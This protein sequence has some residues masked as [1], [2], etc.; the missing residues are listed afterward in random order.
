MRLSLSAASR[1]KGVMLGGSAREYT[2]GHV[3]LSELFGRLFCSLSG[4]DVASH[5]A[6]FLEHL[7]GGDKRERELLKSSPIFVPQP[8][9]IS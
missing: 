9:P 8:V 1:I 4:M 7:L 3:S 5:K 2:R 6:T